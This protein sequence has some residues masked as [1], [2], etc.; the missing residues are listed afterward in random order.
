MRLAIAL[1]AALVFGLNVVGAQAASLP[2][3]VITGTV[4]GTSPN[5]TYTITAS[6]TGWDPQ[7]YPPIGAEVY[8]MLGNGSPVMVY[9]TSSG[10]PI[11]LTSATIWAPTWTAPTEEGYTYRLV[12]FTMQPGIS[13][14]AAVTLMYDGFSGTCASPP[15]ATPA[16]TLAPVA[17]PA[18]AP[19]AAAVSSTKSVQR[20][21]GTSAQSAA[22][23]ASASATPSAVAVATA[24]APAATSLRS[25][26]LRGSAVV[27]Q[28]PEVAWWLT[29]A[30]LGLIAL[31]LTLGAGVVYKRLW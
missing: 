5:C 25:Q 30:L 13:N 20:G 7:A 10:D 18:P 4:G 22:P 29:P 26:A 9:G 24:V 2:Q 3:P 21:S 31:L 8:R 17:T 11:P 16:P 12:L 19:P 23:K 14:Y 1:G 15:A 6:A 27:P 28:A